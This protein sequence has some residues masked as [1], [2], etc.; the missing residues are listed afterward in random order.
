MYYLKT[1]TAAL[2]AGL[3]LSLSPLA[4]Q[5]ATHSKHAATKKADS[6][7]DK[8]A[9]AEVTETTVPPPSGNWEPVPPPGKGWVWSQG[10]YQWKDGR[11]QWKKGEWVA[12][13]EGMDYRQHAWVQKGDKWVLT[14]GDW[15]PEPHAANSK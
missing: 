7:S 12:D 11:Y 2:S 8:K 13:R 1:L 5:A 14:G 4:A 6:K 15:V 9:E 10:Y 3:L